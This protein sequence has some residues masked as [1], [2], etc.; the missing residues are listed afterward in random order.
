MSAGELASMLIIQ[1]SLP[2]AY[3]WDE[4]EMYE[5][6]LYASNMNLKFKEEWEMTRFLSYITC[7]SAPFRKREVKMHDIIKFSW[8]D[9]HK[10]EVKPMTP[11]EI[12][13]LKQKAA[14][15]EKILNK[16]NG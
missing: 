16:Q 12:N 6:D 1:L 3:V 5:A 7:N 14:H 10:E 11:E 13:R 8:D 9:E 15:I 4:M 2:P